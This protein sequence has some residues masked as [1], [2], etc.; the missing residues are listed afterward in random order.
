MLAPTTTTRE[1]E[2]IATRAS[3][4]VRSREVDFQRAR[5]HSSKVRML[6]WVLPVLG[7]G[8]ALAFGSYTFLSRVPQLSYD[9]ASV[10]YADGKLVMSSPELN[11]V[12]SDNRPY[13]MKAD[14]AIQDPAQQNI[15]QL[16]GI[17]AK[18]PIDAVNSAAILAARGVY[19]SKANTLDISSPM[20][21]ESTNGITAKLNSAFLDIDEGMMRTSKPVEIAQNGSVITADSMSVVENGKVLVFENRVRLNIV[22]KP[23][24]QNGQSGDENAGN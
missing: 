16:E 17:D 6:K 20:T 19:D 4:S 5:A 2:L 11:G 9:L 18:V 15:I 14:R 7:I 23:A 12:T 10:A 21:I 3:E 24:G 13:A 1:D 8:I 22:P